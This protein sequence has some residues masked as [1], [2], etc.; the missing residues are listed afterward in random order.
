[1]HNQIRKVLQFQRRK[2]VHMQR[3]HMDRSLLLRHSLEHKRS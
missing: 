2:L 1:V 3:M